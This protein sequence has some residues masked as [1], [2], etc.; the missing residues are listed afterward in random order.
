MNSSKYPYFARIVQIVIGITVVVFSSGKIYACSNPTNSF[1]I[2]EDFESNS[3]EN[4][5]QDN[6]DDFDWLLWSGSTTSG[7]TGP[8]A[9]FE[10]TYYLYTEATTPNN[11]SKV[12]NLI[13]PCFSVLSNLN[14]QIVFAYHMRGSGMGSFNLDISTDDGNT[15]NTL[16]S[17]SGDQGSNWLNAN[18]NLNAYVGQDVQLRF[19]VITGTYQSDVA[20]DNVNITSN[21][22]EEI[23]GDNID[24][25]GDMLI[26][27]YDPDCGV[28]CNASNECETLYSFDWYDGIGNGS[29]WEITNGQSNVT[30][31]Y[32]ISGAKGTY[33]VSVTLNN[34]DGQNIDFSN[35]GY[36]GDH[37]YTGTCND[38]NATVN[39]DGDPDTDDGQF[40]YGC[41]FLTFGITADNSDQT[42]SIT[43]EFEYPSQLCNLLIGDIDHQGIAFTAL[44]SWQD[45]VDVVADSM[46]TPVA[47][48]AVIGSKINVFNNNTPN[49]KLL[50]EYGSS[51]EGNLDHTDPDGQATIT[52]LGKVTSITFTYSN[53]PDDEG[54]SDDHAIRINGFTFC[55]EEKKEICENG[56]D[57]DEDGLVDCEDIDCGF[58]ENNEFKQ[59]TTNWN[60]YNFMGNQSTFTIDNTSQLS[61]IN[62]AKIDITSVGSQSWYTQLEHNN[63]S[64]ESGKTYRIYFEAKASNSREIQIMVQKTL[65]PF[66]TYFVQDVSIANFNGQYVFE[67]TA[68]A[69]DNNV[70]LTFNLGQTTGTVWIDNVQLK[71]TCPDPECLLPISESYTICDEE[72]LTNSVATNDDSPENTFNLNYQITTPPT[73]GEIQFN[74]DGSFVYTPDSDASGQDEFTYERCY[75]FENDLGL[76]NVI[77]NPC[78]EGKIID[79]YIE[80]IEGETSPSIQITDPDDF[81]KVV[82]EVWAESSCGSVTIEGRTAV[83]YELYRTDGTLDSERLYR[84]ELTTVSD[85]GLIEISKTGS[86]PLSSAAAYVERIQSN[87]QGS[88]SLI[89][90]DIDLYHSYVGGDDCFVYSMPIGMS[91]TNRDITFT[92]P[93]HEK[94]NVRTVNATIIAGGISGS[95]S[96]TSWTSIGEG[97]GEIEITLSDVPGDVQVATI[98]VCSPDN[99]GDSFGVGL[100]SASSQLCAE[101][102]TFDCCAEATTTINILSASINNSSPNNCFGEG[103]ATLTASDNSSSSNYT[104]AW[105]HTSATSAQVI[106]TPSETTTYT[107]TVTNDQGCMN[108]AQ[109]TVQVYPELTLDIDFNGTICLEE[110]SQLSANVN[111]GVPNYQYEWTGPNS[112]VSVAQSIDVNVSGNYYVTV[113]D[114]AGCS[115]SMSA[116]V[117]EAYQPFIFTLNT[118]V[119]EGESVDLEINSSSAVG[120]LWD[121]NAGNAT[122]SSVTVTPSPPSTSYTV[123]VTN[124][125]GCETS[126]TATIDVIARPEVV[127]TGPETI[128]VGETS[129]LSP[130]TGGTWES[131]NN[132]VAVVSND[133]TITALSEGNARFIFTNSSTQCESNPSTEITVRPKPIVSVTGPTQICEGFTS[134]LNPTTG[135]VWSSNDE[136]V[137]TVDNNGVV[138]GVSQGNTT[139]VFTQN[140]TGC[141]SDATQPIAVVALPVVNVTG[142]ENICIGANT[143][144]TPTSGGLWTSSDN[145][146]AVVSNGGIVTALAEGTA[147]FTFISNDGCISNPSI[148]ITV[149]PEGTIE[150]TGESLLCEDESTTLSVNGNG[151]FWAS[152]NT[153]IAT[154]NSSGVVTGVAAGFVM[155]SYE[156]NSSSCTS[157]PS[158]LV[159]IISK[160]TVSLSGTTTICVGENTQLTTSG[161]NGFWTSSDPEIAIVSSTGT[162]VGV[163][164]GSVSFNYTNSNGCES[165]AT[166]LITIDPSVEVSVDFN[167]SLCLKDDSQLSAIVTGG[168]SEF[169]YNW[170]GPGGFSANTQSIDIS[171]NGNYSLT[172]TDSKGCSSNTTAFV[173]EAY[174]PFIFA[175][176]TE[177]CEG[178]E[179]TLSVNSSS[180]ASYQW[181]SNAGNSTNQSVTVVP[182]APSTAY[183]VTVTNSIGCTTEATA[184]IDVNVSPPISING[185]DEICVNGTS[186]LIPNS[187]GVWTS[188][189]YAVAT[190]D[191]TGLVTGISN[192]T[193]TFTF[194]NDET[195]CFSEPS[196][197]ITVSENGMLEIVGENQLCLN[198]NITLTATVGGGVWSSS[199]NAI[200]QINNDGIITPISV[201]DAIITYSPVSD[202]CYM[203]ATFEINVYGTPL[204]S[205]NGPSTICENNQTYLSSTLA[206]VWTSSNTAIA[207]VSPSGVVTAI[208]AGT[209][210]FDF[211]T[212]NGC[213]ETLSTPITVIGNPET[214]LNGPADI[215]INSTTSLL[216]ST[217]GIWM[218]SNSNVATVSSS[219]IVTGVNPG[220]ATFT[221]VEFTNGCISDNF[222]TVNVND[223]PSI[224]G[225]DESSLCI[226]E[227]TTITPSSGGIWTSSN[228]SIATITNSGLITA[229]GAGAATFTFTNTLT[230]CTSIASL[231][232]TVENEPTIGFTGPTSICVGETS[233]ISPSAGG[234]WY[235]TDVAVATITSDGT[236]TGI[237]PGSVQFM[238]TNDFTGCTSQSS[239]NLIVE[240]P[241]EIEITGPSSICIGSTTTLSPATGGVWSSSDDNIAMITNSGLVTGLAPGSVTFTFDSALG[242]TS[243]PSTEITIEPDPYVE[244][245]ESNSVC[246]GSTTTISPS[247]GGVWESSNPSIATIDNNGLITGISVGSVNFTFVDNL[248][249]CSATPDALFTVYENPSVSISGSDEICIGGTTNMLP[250][251]GGTWVSSDNYVATISSNGIVLGMH[252]GTA[253]FT[254]YENGS[255]CVSNASAPITI[256]PK[257]NV[258]VTGSTAI[259]VGEET[260][261]EPS[262][263]GAWVSNNE[264]VAIITDQG[265]V[266]GIGQG[267]AKFT[268]ISN[269]GCISNESA[270]VI[271]F[272]KPSIVLDGPNLLCANDTGQMISTAEGTWT[273]TN[274]SIA[275]INNDGIFTAIAPGT[276]RFIFTDSTTGCVSDESQEIIVNDVPDISVIG[277]ANI[278]VGN[279]TNLTPTSGGIW[280]S[281]HPAIASI[282]NNGEVI[283][284]SPG[285]AS[286]IF[287]D[288]ATGCELTANELIT[289]ESGPDISFTGP[290]YLCIGET[291]S[292][293]PS[294]GGVWSSSNENVATID[295]SGTIT[296]V[297]QGSVQFTYVDLST[298]CTSNLSASLTVNGVPTVFVS[299]PSSI[300]L[301]STTTLSPSS[302]GAWASLNPDIASVDLNGNVTGHSTGTAY[303]VFTDDNT[304]CVS[305]SNT[306]IQVIESFDVDILGDSEICIGYTTNLSPSSGGFWTSSNPGIASVTNSGIVT[307]RA[308][309]IVTFE[310]TESSTGC[311]ASS[312]T[313]P[314]TVLL[315]TNHDFNVTAVDL[316]IEGNINTNDNV[317]SGT[318]YNGQYSLVSKPPSSLVTLTINPD[319]TYTFQANKKG[320]YIYAVPVCISP[321]IVGCPATYLEI[322]VVEDVYATANPIGN[323]EFSTTFADTDELVQGAPVE[324]HTVANDNCVFTQGCDLDPSSVSITGG[325][326]KGN[327]SVSLAGVITYTPQPGFIGKDTIYYSV[328]VQDQPLDCSHSFQVVTINHPSALNSIVAADDFAYGLQGNSISGSVIL[329][330]SDPE[331][332][333]ISVLSQG[334]EENQIITD[335]GTYYMDENG[336]FNFTP[337]SSFSGATEIIYTICDNAIS[338]SCTNATLH[339]LVFPDISLKLRVYLEGALMENQGRTSTESGHPLMRDDLRV[340]P[341]TGQNF[342]PDTD[343]YTF[344][345]DVYMDTPSRFIKMGPGLLPENTSIADSLG[346]FSVEGDNAIVDWV[347]VELRSKDDYTVPIA[348][349]SGL[350]QRDGDVVDLDGVSDLRF[351]GINVDSFYVVIKHRSHLGAM[352]M[353]VKND[354]LVDFTSPDF[355]V[356]NYGTSLDDSNDFTGLSQK[357]DVADGYMSLWAGDFDSNGKVKFTNPND[358]QNL[359][360]I[361]VLFS[362]P[363]FLINYDNAYGYF[364]GDYNM[365]SKAKY[366]NPNDDLNYLFS[367]VLLYPLNTSFLSNFNALLEQVPK[368]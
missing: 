174:E 83:E 177:I 129:T 318:T 219:G 265:V 277:P 159:E 186:Q 139:F 228:S 114:D 84:A 38:P 182:G 95:G 28:D 282:Q 112:F 48:N 131:T 199:N 323:L 6:S 110:D 46:G 102:P 7:G 205:V 87:G 100:I 274:T 160:P 237:S 99:N 194:R 16:W 220:I 368:P 343:P 200:A 364:T 270:P 238:Y 108:T 248:T 271:V 165:S 272:D 281:L 355:P 20:I 255:G 21:I 256:L 14:T 296:A 1:P 178:E 223:N 75:S 35:C 175:L 192:G 297:G 295:N 251:S 302:G 179:V 332:D 222:I 144:L 117:Y 230:G 31:V 3:I 356:F 344:S 56:I 335:D 366:T 171:L 76:S 5:M 71:E 211:V 27:E 239:E 68:D 45:E 172:V 11:P 166:S 118:E 132:T 278:C 98:E 67:F 185:P 339:I 197:P 116:Y 338:T 120:F 294:S 321:Q 90:S 202:D 229:V 63:L 273:S 122:S 103:Y 155:I 97:A 266:T 39:C 154:I 232:L 23:C 147:T 111:G 216:P 196:S 253:T 22:A 184:V 133:G 64:I 181:G 191:N 164:A 156:G 105:G 261:L 362:S 158:F 284:I 80:G 53:G 195:G 32:P 348:T 252:A 167:G 325:S 203:D 316:E 189:N 130:T 145:S 259:C 311:V 283:A 51:L 42:T 168:T 320:K 236:I 94:D 317:P 127:V 101:I 246:I 279:S 275:T 269:E 176:N 125:L 77:F 60:H 247:T 69:T 244:Y 233:S 140:D 333:I 305:D 52:S 262:T 300:C 352:S 346:V 319:G 285:T 143:S 61:G 322:N 135:G 146:I 214:S 10:G 360:Y 33:N 342:I 367:Q 89:Q 170:N 141:T 330:D 134:Q 137:A 249:G 263:G 169:T 328:C 293:S 36:P 136:S 43:Y 298:G 363:E 65:I 119:C 123:T 29:V 121:A 152:S 128:C 50:S 315:C 106:V 307:A 241:T 276:V 188:D 221:F 86:C 324:I 303:F 347:H 55:P 314:I 209:V 329:N 4:W 359:L 224:N 24:N 334:S 19:N 245:L 96:T 13:S 190:V 357:A 204:L 213:P 173:Y 41:E 351:N 66:T 242:C 142:P 8:T 183:N 337:N 92:I 309:G 104:Y 235:S 124:D 345:N 353:K 126:A 354:E 264:N 207:V 153:S 82:V 286:F 81:T 327:T 157:D 206:G 88:S 331:G 257:P 243:N 341:F 2:F 308:P 226:G 113:T 151:G 291:S 109:T 54:Q 37:F 365:N 254:F 187:G 358:D 149:D 326:N 62:S 258:E 115:T 57:D 299:G 138:T 312:P 107:V 70:D 40:S 161:S 210:T 234:Y 47:L 208:N 78:G 227:T 25:D 148:P 44:E 280:T 34:P 49:L 72:V 267:L 85:D 58:I 212:S 163:S 361:N 180:A 26:D 336:L 287:T 306:N 250:S 340:S 301:N 240:D 93:L 201:G 150:I 349:R 30:R 292:M 12:A 15:W 304:G 91:D 231:P 215:C 313:D 162:V 18:I 198:E 217:G 17:M 225:L 218:S 193:A 73:K 310:F 59:G 260:T 79:T 268:F 9:A 350:L 289:V 74:E 290:V 288:L